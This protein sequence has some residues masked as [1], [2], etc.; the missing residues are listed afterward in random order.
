MDIRE[1][2]GKAIAATGLVKKTK[3]NEML[4]DVPSQ[5]GPGSYR[6]DLAGTDPTCS[7]PDFELRSQP[8]KHIFAVAYIVVHEQNSDGSTTVTEMTVTATKRKTYPQNWP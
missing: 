4:W 1:E 6:V 7:C 2:R 3:T 8:C 5:S